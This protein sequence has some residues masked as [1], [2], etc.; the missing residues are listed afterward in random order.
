[1]SAVFTRKIL[2]DLTVTLFGASLKIF[3]R[4]E[5]GWKV[6]RIMFPAQPAVEFKYFFINILTIVFHLKES[7]N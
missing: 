5:Y 4:R 6:K 1:M 3:Q 7:Y 2:R